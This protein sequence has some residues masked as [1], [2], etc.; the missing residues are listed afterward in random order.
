MK[1]YTD[2]KLIDQFIYTLPDTFK[3]LGWGRM[4][5]GVSTEVYKMKSNSCIYYLRIL[6]KERLATPQFI[7]HK[8]LLKK[9][10]KV[11]KVIHYEN[12]NKIITRSYMIVDEIPGK[13]LKKCNNLMVRRNLLIKAGE[14]LALTHEIPVKGVGWIKDTVIT[15]R[16]EAEFKDYHDLWLG[17]KLDRILQEL[18][19]RRVLEKE[20]ITKLREI[21]KNKGELIEVAGVGHLAHGDFDPSH[22]YYKNG[23]YTGIIDWGD[24]RSTGIY[25]DLWHFDVFS[26]DN[27]DAL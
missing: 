26:G 10:V 3:N 23:K 16:L 6:P 27:L 1:S 12:L 24:I 11:P 14:Q 21:F 13:P 4:E 9:N 18:F 25:H 22:I 17:K 5:E 7:S 8:L 19:E 20:E 15:K 2:P